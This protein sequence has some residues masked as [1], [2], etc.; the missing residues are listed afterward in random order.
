MRSALRDIG[1]VLSDRCD[2]QPRICGLTALSRPLIAATARAL[3]PQSL[4]AFDFDPNELGLPGAFHGKVFRSRLNASEVAL[5]FPHGALDGRVCDVLLAD[6]DQHSIAAQQGL[7]MGLPNVLRLARTPRNSLVIAGT[8]CSSAQYQQQRYIVGGACM[9]VV[10]TSQPVSPGAVRHGNM[11]RYP[12][13]APESCWLDRWR[14]MHERQQLSN[15]TCVQGK[16]LH[17]V[18]IA[19]ISTAPSLC[20]LRANAPLLGGVHRDEVQWRPSD[21][22]WQPNKNWKRSVVRRLKR[23]WRYLTVLPCE[24]GR[25]CLA[26]KNDLQETFVAAISSV[27]GVNFTSAPKLLVPAQRPGFFDKTLQ[28][29]AIRAYQDAGKQDNIIHVR[30]THNLA[31]IYA[32][33]SYVFAGGRFRPGAIRPKGRPRAHATAGERGIWMEQRASL[34]YF[35]GPHLKPGTLVRLTPNGFQGATVERVK[36]DRRMNNAA[37]PPPA[38]PHLAMRGDHPGCIERRDA[39]ALQWVG[40]PAG[41]CEF[42]GRLA[43]A[44]FNGRFWL[45]ARANLA[46]HG[47]RFVQASS[48]T[49]LHTWSPFKPITVAGYTPAHGE[50]YFFAAQQNPVDAASMIAIFPLVHRASACLAMSFSRDALTWS[51]PR[52]LLACHAAGERAVDQPAVGLL[53]RDGFVHLY[54]HENVPGIREDARSPEVHRNAVHKARSLL[55]PRVVRYKI[56]EADVVRWTNAALDG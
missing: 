40:V 23:N 25:V 19:T 8:N 12:C 6:M 16:G 38:E 42:D 35:E 2:A 17:L 46:V 9:R 26:F 56:P 45:Y 1:T 4:L 27:D 53:R 28:R 43:L 55:E 14:E 49:D 52:S 5:G 10:D 31:I 11:E 41:K 15:G 3:D 34:G 30:T 13:D 36:D 29:G 39:D 32:N 7:L 24:D 22:A 47:Q 44:H 18:C 50:I 48:S 37:S 20:G 54:V 51:T 21:P 33:G